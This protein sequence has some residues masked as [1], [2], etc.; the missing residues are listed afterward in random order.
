MSQKTVSRE[1]AS[2]QPS[3]YASYITGLVARERQRR[4]RLRERATQAME[5]A[6]QAANLLRQHYDV[7]RVRLF[8]SVLRPEHFHERSDIDLAVE[9]LPPEAYLRA[10]AL[11]NGSSPDFKCDFEIDLVDRHDCLPYIW[12]A[13]EREGVD[14]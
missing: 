7:T 11:L 2:I 1:Q 9:G 13:V 5:V 12:E 4:R 10:W 3:K 14:L 6:R 8:G